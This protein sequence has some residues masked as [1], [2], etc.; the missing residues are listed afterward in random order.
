[1]AVM[2]SVLSP[3]F[4]CISTTFLDAKGE[5]DINQYLE[6]CLSPLANNS[7]KQ[8]NKW[9]QQFMLEKIQPIFLEKAKKVHCLSLWT[10]PIWK[11]G[12]PET[13]PLNL[14]FTISGSVANN[15]LMP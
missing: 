6:F 10:L 8:L 7:I 3:F 15:S 4:L 13:L 5:L 14:P 1:V 11:Q 2:T 9:H 12:I